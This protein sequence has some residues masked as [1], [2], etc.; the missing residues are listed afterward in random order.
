M[1]PKVCAVQGMFFDLA[2]GQ[3]GGRKGTW[4]SVCTVPLGNAT[5]GGSK[6]VMKL[7]GEALGQGYPT[8]ERTNTKTH[9]FQ[10]KPH[11]SV[12]LYHTPPYTWIRS[13]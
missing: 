7:V 9:C 8:W 12:T 1:V 3:N 2:A 10:Y 4:R 5:L 11:T 6:D 13:F